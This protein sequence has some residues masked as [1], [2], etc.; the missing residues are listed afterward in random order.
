MFTLF[1]PM[2]KVLHTSYNSSNGGN[3]PNF[4]PRVFRLQNEERPVSEMR[5]Q[6]MDEL[7]GWT[8]QKTLN[9]NDRNQNGDQRFS[10]NNGLLRVLILIG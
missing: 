3:S 8:G 1:T 6:G 7:F 4:V 9:T 5:P 10:L 2:K